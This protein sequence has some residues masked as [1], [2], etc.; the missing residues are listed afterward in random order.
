MIDAAVIEEYLRCV[1][2]TGEDYQCRHDGVGCSVVI[3]GEKHGD[4]IER[5]CQKK[6][7]ERLKPEYVLI[8]VL[9]ALSYNTASEQTGFRKGFVCIDDEDQCQVELNGL[10]NMSLKNVTLV[11]CD[12]SSAELYKEFGHN[13]RGDRKTYPKRETKMG[14]VIT[15][16]LN[17]NNSSKPLVA[18]IGHDH[19][20]RQSKIH[21]LL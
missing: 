16:Y 21:K 17:L 12:L 3:L 7:I 11:G 13:N 19:A 1:R 20:Q 14:E 8:E 15:N 4:C 2:I 5:S 6:L 18:I 9:V 10:L